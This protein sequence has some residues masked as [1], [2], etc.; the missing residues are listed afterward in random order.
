VGRELRFC[1]GDFRG[2]GLNVFMWFYYYEFEECLRDKFGL[3]LRID[4]KTLFMLLDFYS[5]LRERIIFYGIW[6][7]NCLILLS[8][9]LSN[10][11]NVSLLFL[12]YS[13][14]IFVSKE[15]WLH[16]YS[17]FYMSSFYSLDEQYT[18]SKS[19]SMF[20]FSSNSYTE[21]SIIYF[22]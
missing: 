15:S 19:S 14:D 2:Y 8:E 16:F 12:T 10:W 5:F 6:H 21:L 3:E 7:L 13:K 4:V 9:Y 11:S 20:L 22:N 1:Y 17:D 18:L